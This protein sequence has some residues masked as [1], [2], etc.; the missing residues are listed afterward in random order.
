MMTIKELETVY[1]KA[2]EA[3]FAELDADETIALEFTGESSTFV[4]FNGAK[5]RQTGTVN[6]CGAQ[7][8]YYRGKKTVY[9]G[10]SLGFD[11]EV[12]R[13]LL[14]EWLEKARIEAS[15][16]PDDEF[17]TKPESTATSREEFPGKLIPADRVVEEI[18][19]PAQG[20]DFVGLFSQGAI[21]R[22]AANSLGGSHWFATETFIVDYSAYLP[23]GKALKSSYAGRDWDPAEYKRKLDAA[24]PQLEALSKPE[25]VLT[26]GQYRVFVSADAFNEFVVFFSWDGLGERGLREGESAYIALREGRKAFSPK[27]KLTQDFSLGVEPRFNELGEVAP[28]RLTLIEGGK[29]VNTLVSTRTEKQ[30]GVKS[31]GAPAWEGLRSAAVEAGDMDEADALKRI[32][33]GLYV[34]NFHYLN[35]SDSESA[36]VTGMTR[37]ACFWV[38]DGKI[39]APIKDLRFDETLYD[40][41]GDKLEAV[42]KQRHLIV[43][44]S[45]YEQR[46]LGGSL[47]PGILVDKF[48]FTL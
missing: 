1:A 31:N 40:M 11:P 28:E 9:V 16:V 29:L 14:A 3:L 46:A 44:N 4:R 18:L 13:R 42:T 32:G 47:L 34:S 20:L 23:N 17:Q 43:E 35:W 12:N 15:L 26:P 5:V 30:Y 25:K 2:C 6:D 41:L 10:L 21:A 45:T 24:K 48:T 33:T 36:R 27:F 19:A 39:V 37:F 22:G 7:L 38:E 8:S